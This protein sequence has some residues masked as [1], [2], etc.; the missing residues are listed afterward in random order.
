[1]SRHIRPI[2]EKL[3]NLIAQLEA[4]IDFA[5]DDVAVPDNTFVID[6]LRPMRTQLQTLE[7]SFGYGRL[8][9]DG[10]RLAILGKPN[11]GK[12]SLFNRLVGSDRAIVTNI[13]GTTRDVV[14]EAISF[15]GVP[16]CFADTA[17][18]RKTTDEVEQQGVARTFETLAESDFALVVLDGSR[19]M[20]EDD[21]QALEE[22]QKL[23][24]LSVI[25][26]SDLPQAIDVGAVNGSR[27]VHISA[28]TGDGMDKLHQALE[29][30]LLS[31]KANLHD[32]LVLRTARQFEVVSR[33]NE[34][35]V[36][37]ERALAMAIPHEMVLLD[38]YRSLAALD[39]L[40]GESVTDDILDRIFST[41]CVGK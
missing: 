27:R 25:N 15:D 11:V 36:A 35:L 12:S 19:E 41:F 13:P 23:P 16:I 38:L 21:R 1:L 22:A 37:A 29:A 40:T 32:D 28:K 8:L 2:K 33:S 20:D 18:I 10:L 30:F 3:L 34:A 7:E 5:E 9:T 24:H 6:A 4:G 17:G 31:R 26:K 14:K 39:E